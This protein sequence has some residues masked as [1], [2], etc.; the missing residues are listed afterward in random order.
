VLIEFRWQIPAGERGLVQRPGKARWFFPK[1]YPERVTAAVL[2][3]GGRGPE[4]DVANDAA[5]LEA[6]VAETGK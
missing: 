6:P 4:P 5:A 1:D 3:H 2:R